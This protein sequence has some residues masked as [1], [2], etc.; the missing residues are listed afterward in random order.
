MRVCRVSGTRTITG[1]NR[2][3][4]NRATKRIWK[5]NLQSVTVLINGVKKKIRVCAK[6][7]KQIKRV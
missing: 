3:H 1:N 4:S 6:Y 5:P 2:S 7:I